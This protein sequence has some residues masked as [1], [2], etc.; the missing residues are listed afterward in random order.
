MISRKFFRMIMIFFLFSIYNFSTA[1][2]LQKTQ[3]IV[4]VQSQ[5]L[6]VKLLSQ[7]NII[8]ILQNYLIQ[9][10]DVYGASFTFAPIKKNGHLKKYAP[11]VYRK[12]KTITL[13][14]LADS[15]DYTKQDWYALPVREKKSMWS[16]PYFD[17]GGG[18]AWMITYSIPIYVDKKQTHLMGVV[19]NDV[20]ISKNGVKPDK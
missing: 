13:I 16:K 10:P 20:L 15:Y 17:Q 8:K 12:G 14:D 19:T 9:N 1:A 7:K 6:A 4:Q 11:Y 5:Q 2:T 18:N 3:H